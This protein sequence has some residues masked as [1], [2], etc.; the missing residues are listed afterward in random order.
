MTAAEHPDDLVDIIRTGIA[1][2]I[3]IRILA[4]VFRKFRNAFYQ[5]QILGIRDP[6]YHGENVAQMNIRFC[7]VA[8]VGFLQEIAGQGNPEPPDYFLHFEDQIDRNTIINAVIP[9]FRD[10]IQKLFFKISLYTPSCT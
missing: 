4:D 6:V 5:N 3:R 2:I 1:E 7:Y 9:F 10:M 8:E